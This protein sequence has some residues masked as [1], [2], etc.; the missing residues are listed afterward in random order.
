MTEKIYLNTYSSNKHYMYTC[1]LYTNTYINDFIKL[2]SI[3]KLMLPALQD[4]VFMY[5]MI[6]ASPAHT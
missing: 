1:G 3:D 2:S 4:F 5:M 6:T